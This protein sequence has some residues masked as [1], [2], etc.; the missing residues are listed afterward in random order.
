MSILILLLLL[1]VA[2]CLLSLSFF[3][4]AASEVF[5]MEA[6]DDEN[7]LWWDIDLTREE[8]A[9]MK[10]VLDLLV[11]VIICGTLFNPLMK[12]WHWNPEK[13]SFDRYNLGV[14]AASLFIFGNMCMLSFWFTVNYGQDDDENER[15]L[16]D[17]DE[18]ELL[19]YHQKVICTLSFFLALIMLSLGV[20]IYV[21][22]RKLPQETMQ[23]SDTSDAKQMKS[24]ARTELIIDV[25]KALSSISFIIMAI[26][27][28]Y[29]CAIVGR[30]EGDRA[31]EEGLHNLISVLAWLMVITVGTIIV[32]WKIL[33]KKKLDGVLGVGLLQGG[34]LY[35]SLV[36]LMV[37]FLYANP[38]FEGRREERPSTTFCFLL[39]VGYF[40]F[41]RMTKKYEACIITRA[42]SDDI[43]S[44][45]DDTDSPSATGD[46]QRMEDEDAP[47]QE[48]V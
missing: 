15:R 30:D 21:E 34:L 13:C 32:G 2:S 8:E 4:V 35:Y 22:G 43:V 11:L 42:V 16:K 39:F 33:G 19:L 29:T 38:S 9:A 40:A 47:E 41:S 24:G 44:S 12:V 7:N 27:F 5:G 6:K 45:P 36:L 48:M 46:F 28:I 31:R 25:W 18:D 26:Q 10:I 17:E 3:W 20:F 37:F 14:L 1:T 23:A